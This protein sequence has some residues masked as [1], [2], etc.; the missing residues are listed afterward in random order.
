[1]MSKPKCIK[2]G[3]HNNSVERMLKEVERQSFLLNFRQLNIGDF[4][5]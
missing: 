5:Y 1:M 4:A 2:Y 3:I